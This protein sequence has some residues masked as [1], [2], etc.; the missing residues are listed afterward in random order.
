MEPDEISEHDLWTR[1]AKA[2][3]VVW[4]ALWPPVCGIAAVSLGVFVAVGAFYGHPIDP[5]V[6]V[7]IGGFAGLPLF[8]GRS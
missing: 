2:I 6:I 8:G 4:K 3:T 5:Q 1:R 7:M